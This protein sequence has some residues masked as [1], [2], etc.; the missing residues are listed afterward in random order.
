MNEVDDRA[1]NVIYIF[2]YEHV[3]LKHKFVI[4]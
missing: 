4:F 1:I 3:I 2:L